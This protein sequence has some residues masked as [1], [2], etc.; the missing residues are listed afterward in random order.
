MLALIWFSHIN[1]S[2]SFQQYKRKFKSF[3]EE[4][5]WESGHPHSRF[6]IDSSVLCSCFSNDCFHRVLKRSTQPKEECKCRGASPFFL[7]QKLSSKFVWLWRRSWL[8]IRDLTDESHN[9]VE[10]LPTK[11][12]VGTTSFTGCARKVFGCEQIPT[13]V[14]CLLNFFCH[15]HSDRVDLQGLLPNVGA[16]WSLYGII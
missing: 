1:I 4:R 10:V 13:D 2:S 16:S 7:L 15:T 12:S 6:V 11:L 9:G 14:M 5:L 8:L 3:D